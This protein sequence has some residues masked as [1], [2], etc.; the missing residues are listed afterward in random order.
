ML[1]N[2]YF[3]SLKR[4]VGTDTACFGY[5]VNFI[6]TGYYIWVIRHFKAAFFINT[7]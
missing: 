2:I 1:I 6:T 3:F 7:M 4:T 5:S